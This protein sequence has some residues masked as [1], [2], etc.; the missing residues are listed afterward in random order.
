MA[1]RVS[2]RLQDYRELPEDCS[3]D[4]IASVGMV[5]H[6]GRGKLSTFLGKA[7]RLLKPGGLFLNHGI[8]LGRVILPAESGSL[9][10]YH[11]FPDFDLDA[12][13]IY[14]WEESAFIKRS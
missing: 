10:Q 12:P 11:V 4:A 6:V 3:N 14:S 2:A 8:G 9:I 7:L 1:N 5:E 13:T